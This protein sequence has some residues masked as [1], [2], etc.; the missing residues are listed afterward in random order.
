M[1]HHQGGPRCKR[2]HLRRVQV[3]IPDLA[4]LLVLVAIM[5]ALLARAIMY[6]FETK[7]D[8]DDVFQQDPVVPRR[9]VLRE[10]TLCRRRGAG[11]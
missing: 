1:V 11:R 2:T 5:R 8:R 4:G 10:E 9:E 3:F 6:T 7:P